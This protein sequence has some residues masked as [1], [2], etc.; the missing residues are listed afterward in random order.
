MV[1]IYKRVKTE[2]YI[3]G[4]LYCPVFESAWALPGFEQLMMDYYMNPELAKQ[5][6]H[7]TYS[8]HRDITKN[9]A[10]RGVDMI[11]LGD[12]PMENFYAMP[13][14]VGIHKTS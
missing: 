1:G 9:M 2:Y 4:R 8:Y 10:Q 6:L 3:I 5:I 13:E 7:L 12:A 14:E 11:W